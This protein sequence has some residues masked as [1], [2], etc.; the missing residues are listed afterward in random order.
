MII[1]YG[2]ATLL[3]FISTL[4]VFISMFPWLAVSPISLGVAF[5]MVICYT[6]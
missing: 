6:R 1:F 4:L 2:T 5:R 3:V